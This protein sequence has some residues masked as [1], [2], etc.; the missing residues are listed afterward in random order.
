[1]DILI[2]IV[3]AFIV[4]IAAW[5][6]FYAAQE[7]VESVLGCRSDYPR[8]S[9]RCAGCHREGQSRKE[10][11]HRG[12]RLHL[13]THQVARRGS[14][15]GDDLRRDPEGGGRLQLSG[16]AHDSSPRAGPCE[17]QHALAQLNP[18]GTAGNSGGRRRDP[19]PP[20]R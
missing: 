14:R 9:A 3:I 17:G 11:R 5:V 6:G 13:S 12:I 20:R 10:G 1:M 8:Q 7:P 19:E 15:R 4:G 2:G 16:Q 18:S